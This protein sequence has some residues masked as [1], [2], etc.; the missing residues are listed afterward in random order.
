LWICAN[1]ENILKDELRQLQER[2]FIES[3]VLPEIGPLPASSPASVRSKS[4]DAS[5]DESDSDSNSD[6][7]DDDDAGAI[8]DDEEDE[9]AEKD[10]KK[11]GTARSSLRPRTRHVATKS[12]SPSAE[13]K[14]DPSAKSSENTPKTETE[15]AP[16]KRKRGR[17]PKIDTPE[18]ARIRSIL[19]AIRKV[20][21][22]DGRQL[23]LEFEKLPDP[24]Q[25]P[26]YYKEIK[27]PIALDHI[28]VLL[29][30][31]TG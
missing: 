6:D 8:D 12:G 20:K 28:T 26:D 25:Y 10:L 15:V 7:D 30:S 27:R 19:R 3:A 24:E 23:F 22:S 1:L 31:H 5:S 18:E 11:D 14:K 13:D 21:D 17:P 2:G 9:Y 29:S 4:A 16:K